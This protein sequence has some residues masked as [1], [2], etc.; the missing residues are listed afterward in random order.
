MTDAQ[1]LEIEED[2]S[3]EWCVCG[4]N[5]LWHKEGERPRKDGFYYPGKCMGV[6][7]K[8]C[9]CKSFH[10]QKVKDVAAQGLLL[11]QY[12][13]RSRKRTARSRLP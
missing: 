10:A 4:C 6:L 1:V 9:A 3:R 7:F 5:V 2:D 12:G 8:G 11:G 13:E